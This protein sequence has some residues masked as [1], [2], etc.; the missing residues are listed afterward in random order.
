MEENVYQSVQ[1]A[2]SSA[3]SVS[4]FGEATLIPTLTSICVAFSVVYF[5]IYARNKHQYWK[6]KNVP[7]P[8]P[9]FLLGHFVELLRRR[10]A[11]DMDCIKKYGK[12]YGVY[13]GLRPTLV[14]NDPEVMETLGVKDFENFTD[15]DTNE[16]FTKYQKNFVFL[17]KGHEWKVL[18]VF[19]SPTFTSRKI[20]NMFRFLDVCAD[21]LV[22]G[23]QQQVDDKKRQNSKGGVT[24]HMRDTYNL[25]TLDAITTCCFGM[26]LHRSESPNYK[27]G[28]RSRNELL[29]I[30]ENLIAFNLPRL[31]VA[32]SIPKT[33]LRAIGFK[34]Q[35]VS[36]YE[37]LANEVRQM[38]EARK[39]AQEEKQKKFDDYLQ[40]LVDARL[41]DEM[42]LG[43]MDKEENHHAGI[44]Q[45]TLL[46]DQERIRQEVL[47]SM[48]AAGTDVS[49]L[50]MSDLEV[51][52][53]CL[54]MLAVGLDTTATLL[55]HA[56]YTL[57][58]H[59]DIQDRLH[60]EVMKIAEINKDKN[61]IR[62]EYES[63]TTCKYLDAVVSEVLRILPPIFHTDRVANEDYFLEKYKIHIPKGEVIY[64]NWYGVMNNSEFW[65]N[66]EKFDPERFMP[67]N[68]DKI[69][70]GAYCPFG[71]GPR[72]CVGMR[73]G[74]SEAKLAI[75]K[76]VLKFRFEPVPGSPFPPDISEALGVT[77]MDLP[78]VVVYRRN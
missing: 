27:K 30:T 32:Q 52:S 20:R 38:V 7:G 41:Q 36:L 22:E 4:L 53:N 46:D 42:D 69:K 21:D 68:K 47:A 55:T 2:G 70:K 56:A 75:G 8:T 15:H 1:D 28:V 33:I 64:M 39:R 43:D 51:V 17:K 45:Q 35:K 14:V 58:H 65:E 19:I 40:M 72:H 54:F 37:P 59:Q 11:F 57:A 76:M 6:R 10:V 77:T 3:P 12:V 62:F 29:A 23:V 13:L 50:R 16:F 61:T 26:K 73:F 66:P 49:K 60:D 63:L 18:R 25:Y 31:L 48:K 44:S 78:K 9:T 67:E 34:Q 5:S 24:V 74:L 71:V